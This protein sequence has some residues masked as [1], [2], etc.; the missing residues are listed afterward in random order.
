MSIE[1]V[2]PSNHLILCHPL[3][4]LPSI[5]PSI[6]VFFQWVGSLDQ[7][8]K[9]LEFQLQHQ[10]FQWTFR[11]SFLSDW[12]VWSPCSPGDSQVSSAAPQCE[13]I[14][15]STLSLLYG[16]TLTFIHYYWKNQSFD[17]ADKLYFVGK[18]TSLLFNT[19]SRFVIAFLPRTKHL[20]FMAAY[21]PLLSPF[22]ILCHNGRNRVWTH[23]ISLFQ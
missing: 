18:I 1:S 9:V 23:V 7:V 13:S 21:R 22:C 20:N 14:N 3:L 19:L 4:L 15:S 10:S 17:Y 5:F 6:R 2:M 12:L 11:T 8:A 16:Q